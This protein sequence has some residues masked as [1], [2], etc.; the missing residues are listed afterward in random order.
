M[1]QVGATH[2]ELGCLESTSWVE[3]LV[4]VP[5]Q[6]LL[7]LM[8]GHVAPSRDGQQHRVLRAEIARRHVRLDNTP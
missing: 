3:W 8:R 5:A 4:V 2:R 7:N 6:D 1:S